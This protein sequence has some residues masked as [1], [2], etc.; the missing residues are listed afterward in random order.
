M[1]ARPQVL[2]K[3]SWTHRHAV[4]HGRIVVLYPKGCHVHDPQLVC[5]GGVPRIEC[6]S[7]KLGSEAMA[8]SEQLTHAPVLQPA[9]HT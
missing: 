1:A 5:K 4:A 7:P 9:H 2:R 8:V 3:S 6:N